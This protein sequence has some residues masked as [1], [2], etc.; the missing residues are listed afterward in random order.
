L[1]S[2]QVDHVVLAQARI[3]VGRHRA[4]LGQDGGTHGEFDRM[5]LAIVEADGFDAGITLQGPG[6]ASGGVLSATEQYEGGVSLKH[7]DIPET[8]LGN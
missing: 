8:F 4:H 6:Q 5:A 7:S 1:I 2:R 3:P